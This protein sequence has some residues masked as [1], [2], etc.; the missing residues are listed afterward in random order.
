MKSNWT[1]ILLTIL[2]PMSLGAQNISKVGTSAAQFLKIPVGAKAASMGNAFVSVVDNATAVYWNPAGIASLDRLQGSLSHSSWIAGLSHDFFGIVIPVGDRSSLGIS[3]IALQSEKIEQTTIEAPEGTGT[4]FDA[5]DIAVG[6]TYA[7]SMT[8]NVDIGATVKYVNQRIW[9]ES[10]QTF[11]VDFGALLRTGINDLKLGLSF[12]NFGPGMKMSG[13]ELIRQLD[14]DPTS[15]ANPYVE[16]AIQTQEWDL[17]TSYRVSTSMSFIGM[18]GLVALGDTRLLI[19]LDA[20]HP[21]DSPERYSIGGE[22]SFFGTL[23]VR[24]GY[25]FNTDEEG[26]T[27]GAGLKIPLG[28]TSVVFDYAY[29]E[30]GLLGYVQ[31][32]TLSAA[33]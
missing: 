22:Y 29:G 25:V 26:L 7:R 3:G 15:S 14:Q 30:F 31:H 13:R 33:F 1:G 16:S 24:G 6:I 32:F 18:N 9:S 21:N 28:E 20:V 2:L 23:A 4:F 12:Q 10:A 19:A 11:A 17:P 5:M 27:L 8:D